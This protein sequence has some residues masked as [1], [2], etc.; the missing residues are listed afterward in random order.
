MVLSNQLRVHL[1]RR[2]LHQLLRCQSHSVGEIEDTVLMGQLELCVAG[3]LPFV[4]EV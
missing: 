2:L 3:K 4:L 1:P